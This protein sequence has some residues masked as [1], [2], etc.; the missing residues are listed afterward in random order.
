MTTN[1][2]AERELSGEQIIRIIGIA[3]DDTPDGIN[4]AVDDFNDG[5]LEAV[6]V[7]NSV[8]AVIAAD[9][10][11]RFAPP[12]T[13]PRSELEATNRRI[14]ELQAK[15]V[16]ERRQWQIYVEDTP[17]TD[18]AK[19]ELALLVDGAPEFAGHV[20]MLVDENGMCPA[21]TGCGPMALLN[22]ELIVAAMAAAPT[23]IVDANKGGVP[24]G[25]EAV[26]AQAKDA[27]CAGSRSK[28]DCDTQ[29][30]VALPAIEFIEERLSILSAAPA[31]A[32]SPVEPEW[33]A[34]GDSLPAAGDSVLVVL[35]ENNSVEY[36][37]SHA[38]QAAFGAWIDKPAAFTIYDGWA[39]EDDITDDVLF[40]MPLPALPASDLSGSEK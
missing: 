3:M 19:R 36:T 13:V 34:V 40:W 18:D 4:S 8:R 27:L 28:S 38:I 10:D 2:D 6:S 16:P 22:A 21:V 7:V 25:W 32:A 23:P 24:E 9:R 17:T 20:V 31:P 5:D 33:I 29:L 11:M 12:D 15:A 30:E 1:K 26:I 37:S 14:A 39:G 35:R